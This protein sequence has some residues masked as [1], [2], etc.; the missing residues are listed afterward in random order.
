M[1]WCTS[2]VLITR[3][4]FYRQQAFG[5]HSWLPENSLYMVNCQEKITINST[6]CA[7]SRIKT[8]SL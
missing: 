2:S 7:K 6:G 4:A 3:S 8:Y 1:S 5:E